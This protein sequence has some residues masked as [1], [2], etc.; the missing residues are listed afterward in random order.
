VDLKQAFCQQGFEQ[1]A[2]GRQRW[3]PS[4]FARN[5]ISRTGVPIHF[6]VLSCDLNPKGLLLFEIM[7]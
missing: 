1:K 3:T 2:R 4:A 5:A 6:L 7:P